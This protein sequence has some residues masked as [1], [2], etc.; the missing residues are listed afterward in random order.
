[1]SSVQRE[2]WQPECIP[3]TTFQRFSKISNRLIFW[4]SSKFLDE[5][6]RSSEVFGNL[7]LLFYS[8]VFGLSSEMLGQLIGENDL[9]CKLMVLF[10]DPA[11]DS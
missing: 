2:P 10:G 1:M 4:I 5:L 9:K 3:S 6:E 11:D 7:G 8:D